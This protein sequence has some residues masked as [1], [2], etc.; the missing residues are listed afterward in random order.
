MTISLEK[1]ARALLGKKREPAV[2]G[3]ER[4]EHGYKP[5]ITLPH[6]NFLTRPYPDWWNEPV[7]P[8]PKRKGDEEKI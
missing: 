4:R 8:R 7:P 3:G 6:V 2:E 1:A 5:K